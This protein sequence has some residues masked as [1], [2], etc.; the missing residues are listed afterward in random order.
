VDRSAQALERGRLRLLHL[1]Q[2]P[3]DF[4][5]GHEDHFEAASVRAGL[6]S[7][8]RKNG[9]AGYG[10]QPRRHDSA[11]PKYSSHRV[12]KADSI[13]AEMGQ[14]VMPPPAAIDPNAPQYRSELQPEPA[15]P[16]PPWPRLEPES[17]PSAFS[18]AAP[19]AMAII[20]VVGAVAAS[21]ISYVAYGGTIPLATNTPLPIPPG[22][23]LPRPYFI[24]LTVVTLVAALVFLVRPAPSRYRWPWL[25]LGAFPL[26]AAVVIGGA[27]AIWFSGRSREG[28]AETASAYI[29]ME[30][31][32]TL[33]VAACCAIALVL[34]LRASHSW[35]LT[36]PALLYTPA[37]IGVCIAL[38]ATLYFESAWSLTPAALP[39]PD[40]TLAARA[41]YSK[42]LSEWFATVNPISDRLVACTDTACRKVALT[43]LLVALGAFDGAVRRLSVPARFRSDWLALE[44]ADNAYEVQLMQG[45]Q[46]T[47]VNFGAAADEYTAAHDLARDLGI[48]GY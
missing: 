37:A 18:P 36:Q 14:S 13:T 24:A 32:V 22:Y 39:A 19:G 5:F 21:A 23:G 16:E 25:W 43:D 27:G 9:A 12:P 44:R 46:S 40:P 38:V 47:E 20:G 26:A 2:V 17:Q 31:V 11:C 35:P 10:W 30:T 15:A 45:F 1:G 33:G 4:L 8:P 34:V 41:A 3:V 42:P 48:P 7:R 28:L 6:D 29:D